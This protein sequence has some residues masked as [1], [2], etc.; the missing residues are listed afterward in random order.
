M[1]RPAHA[2]VTTALLHYVVIFTATAALLAGCSGSQSPLSPSLQ[3]LPSQQSQAEATYDILHEF[4]VSSGDG[5]NPST[6]LI[7]VKGTLYGTT[8]FGGAYGLGTVFSITKSGKETVLH[9]FGGS[10]DA[11]YPSARLLEVNGALYGTTSGGIGTVFVVMKNGKETVLHN[12]GGPGDGTQPSGGLIKVN[13]LL[14]GTTYTGGKFSRGIIFSIAKNGTE[15]VL[16]N[17]G[18]KVDDA[19]NP[20]AGLLDIGGTL[21]GTSYYGGKYGGEFGGGTVF[22]VSTAGKER[23]LYSFGGGGINDGTSPWSTLIYV[24]GELYGTTQAGGSYGNSGTV[25]SITLGGTE[26]VIHSFS[27]YSKTDGAFPDAGLIDVRGLLYG[28]T[29]MG[30][31][32]GVGTVFRITTSGEEN[33]VHSF[34]AGAGENPRAGLLAVGATLYGTTYGGVREQHGN[35]FSLTP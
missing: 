3:E 17:F 7:N 1:K 32:K 28:T 8:V 14:Y 27:Y 11:S 34:R 9:S 29:P 26:K 20:L 12:F 19:A 6:E 18:Q 35:V 16:Y 4:G 22:S 21:Y 30:G 24:N 13:D 31:A 2:V 25:F 10:G 15:K 23:V 33:L 5:A